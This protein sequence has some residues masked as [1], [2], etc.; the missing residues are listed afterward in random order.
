MT[1]ADVRQK[2]NRRYEERLTEAPWP[3]PNPLVLRFLDRVHGGI[4]LDAACGLGTGIAAAIDRV[5]LAVGV[6]L[7][8]TALAAARRHWGRHPKI[9]W[10]QADVARLRWPPDTFSVVCAF[11]FTDWVFL[12][13]VP[14]ILRPGGLFLYQGFSRRHL[15]V[16]PEFDPDWTSTPESIAALFPGWSVLACEESAEPPYRVSFAG[17]RPGDDSQERP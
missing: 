16:K 14:C 12:S 2:W 1:L 3:E 15:E 8:E 7:S 6:D 10:I 4:L 5:D 11:G 9:R 17:L 13:Q